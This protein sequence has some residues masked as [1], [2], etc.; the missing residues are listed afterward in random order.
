MKKFGIL[1]LFIISLIGCKQNGEKK[2]SNV[3]SEKTP[4]DFM[5]MQRAYPTGHIRTE[6]YA[7]AVA[8]KKRQLRLNPSLAVWEFV[9][10]TNIGGRV[11]DVE[12]PIDKAETFY[13]GAA[14]G[15]VFKTVD[16][17]ANW[18]P[19]FDQEG[20]LSIGDIEISKNDTDVIWVGTGEVN[21]GGGSLA[22]GGDGI[23]KSTDGGMNWQSKGL[24]NVG[25]IGKVL[26][27]PNDD[28]T[29]FVG[30]MGPLFRDDPN[31]GVYRSKD[32]GD[33]WTKVLFVS[34]IAGIIDM[35][36]HPTNSEII[37]AASWE[38]IRR[39]NMRRYGGEGSNLYRSMDGGTTWSKL[40]VGLPSDPMDKGRIS[41]DISQS[42]PNILYTRYADATGCIK[43]VY[44]TSDGGDSWVEVNSTQLENVCFHWW[45]RGIFVDPVDENTIYNVDFKVQKST[46]GGNNWFDAFPGAH[47]DQHA[48][49]FNASVSGEVLLGND[50][51]LYRSSDSG[52]TLEK[53]NNLPITQFYRFYVDSQNGDKIY[54][55]SQDNQHVRTTTG[56]IDDWVVLGGNDGLQPLVQTDNTNVLYLLSQSGFL[57]KSINDGEG[58][59]ADV[60]Q[61]PGRKNW[62]MPIRLDPQEPETLY[63]AGHYVA[64]STDGAQNWV[65]ISPDITNGDG[66]GNLT[67]GTATSL[68]ISS[69]DSN[70]IY[71]GTDEGNAWTTPDGGGLW[72]NISEGLPDRWVT[73]IYASP[74]DPDV[75]YITL[76]GYRFGEDIGHVYRSDNAGANWV[77]IGSN[78]PDIP[79]NDILM[80][81]YGNLYLATDVGVLASADDGASWEV[82]GENMPPVVVTDMHIHETDELLYVATYG[83]SAYKLDLSSNPLAINSAVFDDRIRLYPNPTSDIVYI[84]F[85]QIPE[86]AIAELYDN[87]GRMVLKVD[88]FR[89]ENVIDVSE[90]TS[91]IYY[92]KI[93]EGAE[94]TVKKLIIK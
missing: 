17:G 84:K 23:Y 63:S 36:I 58:F 79:V 66:G 9:G 57:L 75:V 35:A 14:S 42:N 37:Y 72:V 3:A 34:E 13:L 2:T 60:R 6:A 25:S 69:F 54:G 82:L 1:F 47:V 41:I 19:I 44:R 26:I 32:G 93:S 86:N 73:S 62:D 21:A 11:T 53:F 40:T 18:V 74:A 29:I 12:I 81:S 55:G 10:P 5:F 87:L 39:H 85:E 22:Y 94:S 64:K 76:S 61:P 71:A 90:V 51:G 56:G 91:G 83:R 45:F 30:A 31:K 67:F 28:N 68:S 92:V 50:G 89:Q 16:G 43:G 33:T 46:D 27:D 8:W 65:Q 48:L 77:N 78:L 38:R 70:R 49:A 7:E 88:V 24:P 80:D 20:M 52:V 59:T 15:G 4:H